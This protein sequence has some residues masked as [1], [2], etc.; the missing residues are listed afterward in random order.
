MPA[1]PR[2]PK[3]PIRRR[4]ASPASAP[5]RLITTLTA[6]LLLAACAAPVSPGTT[7]TPSVGGSGSPGSP[8][9]AA[10]STSGG[11]SAPPLALD[12]RTLD[13]C[14]LVPRPT[15]EAAVGRLSGPAPSAGLSPSGKSIGCVYTGQRGRATVTLALDLYSK[16]SFDKLMLGPRNVKTEPIGGI[17]DGA[18]WDTSAQKPGVGILHVLKAPVLASFWL[19]MNGERASL[20]SAR[21]MVGAFLNGL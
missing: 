12:P 13:P 10:G 2:S 20:D 1:S 6:A 17:G 9:P 21:A 15:I 18:Y 14:R 11:T 19:E 3:D 8:T 7:T 4:P 16:A 5:R